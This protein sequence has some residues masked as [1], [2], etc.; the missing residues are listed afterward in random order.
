MT[1]IPWRVKNFLSERL[2]LLYH[3]AANFGRSGNSPAHWDRRLAETWD[4]PIRAWPTKNSLIASLTTPAQ[5]ILDIGCGDGS[6]LRA[7]SSRGYQKL[8]GQELSRYAIDRLGAC[9]I[10]MRH[11]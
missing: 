11:G 9:G 2:P 6:L 10:E 4:D 3:F 1:V 8:F 5:R 7:L